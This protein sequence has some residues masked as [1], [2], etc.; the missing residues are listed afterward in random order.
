ML[1]AD[2]STF[3]QAQS[4]ALPSTKSPELLVLCGHSFHFKHRDSVDVNQNLGQAGTYSLVCILLGKNKIV[5]L[6]LNYIQV[7]CRSSCALPLLRCVLYCSLFFSYTDKGRNFPVTFVS[8][9]LVSYWISFF[10]NNALTLPLAKEPP[11]KVF[12]SLKKT[13]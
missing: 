8:T 6:L 2:K 10:S 13:A 7:T 3:F 12:A 11:Q 9:W 1:P 5:N 4:S